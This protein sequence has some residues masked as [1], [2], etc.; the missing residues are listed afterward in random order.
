MDPLPQPAPTNV[1]NVDPANPRE[2][3]LFQISPTLEETRVD[4]PPIF[5]SLGLDPSAFPK[6]LGGV[7]ESEPSPLSLPKSV[8][9]TALR[10]PAPFADIIWFFKGD[11]FFRYFESADGDDMVDD[12][13]RIAADD[14]SSFAGDWPS[15]FA[16]GIDAALLGTGSFEGKVWFFKGSEYF[17]LRLSDG[18]VDVATQSI[19][20]N[21]RGVSDEFAGKG[22]DAAIH[23]L[24]GF[25]GKIWFF[26]GSQFLRYNL[27]LDK[28]DI[29]PLPIRGHWGIGFGAGVD[30]WPAAFAD[31]VDFAFYGTGANAEKIYFFRGDK[32]ILYSL[33]T[34]LVEEGPEPIFENWPKL[35]RFMPLPQLFIREHYALHTFRGEAG[36]GAIVGTQSIGPR[37]KTEFFIL[38]R[39]SEESTKISSSNILES[40]SEE[41]VN[42]LSEAVREDQSEAGSEEKYDYNLDASFQGE[43]HATLGGGEAKAD[44]NV[45]GGS[46]DVRNSFA[47]AVGNQLEKKAT[48]THDIHKEEIHT[49]GET[50]VVNE[51]T[52]TGFKQVV[53]NSDNPK[54]LNCLIFQLIQE[55][56]IVL[57]LVDARLAFHNGDP[58]D[59]QVERIRDMAELLDQC[60]V[61]PT[62]RESLA[63]TMEDVFKSIVDHTGQIRSLIAPTPNDP[64]RF[65]VDETLT[66]RF[67]VNDSTG[68][69][70]RSIEV[71]GI[72][73]NVDRPTVLTPNTLMTLVDIP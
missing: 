48:Q 28:V 58:R 9:D 18:V 59:T 30:T 52:E 42:S 49:A 37:T 8:F 44:L 41:A 19:A 62:D 70:L 3:H 16:T 43:A 40:Q 15:K 63:L 12:A 29:N 64:E 6:K 35:S 73:L 66:S 24:G 69:L 20:G 51:E 1:V 65:Q 72:V 36:S 32:Y 47:K 14:G 27:E 57:T 38:R 5:T 50:H 21:W 68:S 7:P 45:K 22:I 33:K 61:D 26:K 55:Y 11:S 31:G 67:E 13:T 54:P 60:I 34:D 39:K 2:E 53:D 4:L 71:P 56:I 10:A 46:Q 23:G 25:F 17:R